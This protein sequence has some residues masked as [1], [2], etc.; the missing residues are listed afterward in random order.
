MNFQDHAEIQDIRDVNIQVETGKGTISFPAEGSF[1]VLKATSAILPFSLTLGNTV[2]KSATVQPLTI[3]NREKTTCHIFSAIPGIEAEINVPSNTK[4]TQLN[5]AKVSTLGTM[6]RVK[7]NSDGPFSFIANGEQFLVIPKSMALNAM[8]IDNHLI[9]SDALLLTKKDGL[10]L[11]SR[12][13]ENTIHI[14]PEYRKTWSASAAV[15]RAIKPAFSGGS[16]YQVT[17][18]EVKPDIQIEQVSARKYT[19]RL[20]SDIDRLNDVFIETDYIGDRALAFINGEIITDHFYHQRSWE[21]GLRNFAARLKE[22]EMLFFFH[23]VFS[24]YSYLGDLKEQP[25]FE[26]GRYLKVNDFKIIPEYKTN[27]KF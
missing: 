5:N 27:L 14:F 6:K 7:P 20:N 23:P 21:I 8:K 3:L 26:N 13:T 12:E 1:D 16:S 10:E 17:F 11:I 19:L 2:I 22:Q 25:D 9:I 4:I 18:Q 15:V 24:T